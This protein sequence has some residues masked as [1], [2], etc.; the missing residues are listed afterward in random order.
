M[1]QP[2]NKQSFMAE[3]RR[4]HFRILVDNCMVGTVPDFRVL[5]LTEN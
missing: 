5:R 4:A 2:K 3:W 1:E